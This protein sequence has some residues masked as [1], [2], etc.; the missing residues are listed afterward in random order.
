MARLKF[1]CCFCAAAADVSTPAATDSAASVSPTTIV[2]EVSGFCF[3]YNY[4]RNCFCFNISLIF[5]A[6]LRSFLDLLR[7]SSLQQLLLY[8]STPST[9]SAASDCCVLATASNVGNFC[10]F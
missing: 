6:S 2:A 4:W 10:L 3:N 7:L 5:A 8:F 1:C 9:A